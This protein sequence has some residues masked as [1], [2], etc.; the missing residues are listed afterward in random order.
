ME[1][2]HRL[3]QDE[4]DYWRIRPFLREVMVLNGLHEKSWPAMRWD[5]W[6]WHGV[7]NCHSVEALEK[8]IHLWETEAGKLAA[9][10]IPET[11]GS[12]FLQV[13][14]AFK[15]V[16]LEEEMIETAEAF[17]TAR[18]KEKPRLGVWSNTEDE[19][20]MAILQ[21]RGYTPGAT[22]END[23]W[24]DLDAPIRDVPVAAGYTIRSLGDESELPARSWASW[25]GFHPNEPD[26]KYE[27]WE[28]YHNVQ[29]CPLYRRDLDIVAATLDG[30]IAAFCTVWLDDVTRTA[31]FE[32]VATVPEHQRMGLARAVITEGLRR[33]RRMGAIR[34]F[35]GGMEPGPDALYSSTLSSE[36]DRAVEWV[37]EW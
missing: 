1:L 25:R 7:E 5:Y 12:V 23:W 33:V 3:Y 37:K 26:S 15:T 28:W 11:L 18:W 36:C 16:E 17:L 6:R 13:H 20:R 14:P 24:V 30:T 31:D 10:L 8:V 2:I 9:V 19:L 29:R 34:A 21:R 27:G 4:N 22:Y 35:V 32:P